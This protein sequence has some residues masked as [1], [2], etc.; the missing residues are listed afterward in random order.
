MI[1]LIMIIIV[2]INTSVHN[3]NIMHSVKTS[4]MMLYNGGRVLCGRALREHP[5]KS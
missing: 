1:I 4:D 5:V 2:C 3:V